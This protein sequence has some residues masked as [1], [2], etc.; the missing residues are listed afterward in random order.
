MKTPKIKITCENCI[1]LRTI[2]SRSGL[3]YQD[4][5]FSDDFFVAEWN[6]PCKHWLPS[7]VEVNRAILKEKNRGERKE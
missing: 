2:V 5:E 3:E 1:R 6:E 7:A 4:C